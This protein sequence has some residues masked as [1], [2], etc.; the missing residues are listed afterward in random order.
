MKN[1][2]KTNKEKFKDDGFCIFRKVFTNAEIK[3]YKDEII[4]ISED[5][6]S[7]QNEYDHGL[8]NYKNL[9]EV[10]TNTKLLDNLRYLFG[11]DIYFLHDF[12]FLYKHDYNYSW[13]RDNPCRKFGVGPDW[14]KSEEYNVA[15]VGIY[16]QSYEETKSCLNVIPKS[17]NRRY[18]FQEGLRFIHNR[19]KNTKV[20]FIL[21][22]REF[23][24]KYIGVNVHNDPGDCIIFN[25]KLWHSPSPSI[26][27]KMAFFF[28]FGIKNKHS[29]NYLD[30][31][32]NHRKQNGLF[33]H[34]VSGEYIKF[35]KE[36]NIYIEI[37]QDK[38]NI[39]GVFVPANE[40]NK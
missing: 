39:E 7:K 31:H 20:N 4:K 6:K 5:T 9:R 22:L 32:F 10:I 14:D 8:D 26:K 25:A 33:N 29:L 15:R 30:Y 19:L 18:T 24:A 12:S 40:R 21:K 17:H 37:P 23:L 35:L 13:H 28:A 3:K 1:F 27:K 11:K 2:E 38:K 34:N 16:L 36:N